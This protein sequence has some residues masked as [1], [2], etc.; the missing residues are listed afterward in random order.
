MNAHDS[1]NVNATSS[2][3][4]A[5]ANMLPETKKRV[6][7]ASPPA[8]PKKKTKKSKTTSKHTARSQSPFMPLQ[9]GRRVRHILAPQPRGDIRAFKD[10]LQLFSVTKDALEGL[11]AL[12]EEA[13]ILHGAVAARHI[14]INKDG[15]GTLIDWD[16]PGL[17]AFPPRRGA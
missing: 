11:V 13:G 1:H 17:E 14:I 9:P 10:A 2:T 12:K 15:S 4:N 7:S 5:E 16:M 6:P 3:T 8:S